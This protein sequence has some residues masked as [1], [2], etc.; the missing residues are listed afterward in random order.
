MKEVEKDLIFYR[1]SGGGVTLSGGEPV[2]QPEFSVSL[3]KECHKRGIHTAIETCGFQKWDTLLRILQYVDLVLYDL[4][5]MSSIEHVQFTGV[6]NKI[7]LENA[8]KI[9]SEKIPMIIRMPVIPGYND[10]KANI[11][12]TAEFV[13][14]LKGVSKI[15]LLPYH[16]LGEPKYEKLGRKYKLE[17]IS[18]PSEEYMQ[19]LLS[20][21]ECYELQV[22]IGGN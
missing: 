16:R 1:S 11:K 6:D 3:L 18:A 22:Q 15:D 13:T 5:C 20:I 7:I 8:Q 21:I 19:E 17:G 9:A 4:K 10:S 2:Y 12:T 14:K